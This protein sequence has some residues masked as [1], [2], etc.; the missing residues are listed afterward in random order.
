[1]KLSIILLAAGLS[2]RMGQDKLL[3]S[4]SNISL[5]QSAFNL[6]DE[7]DAF[8]KIVVTTKSRLEQISLPQ[9]VL[10]IINEDPKRGQSSSLCLGV[11]N[12]TGTHYLFMAADQP[13][14]TAYDIKQITETAKNNPD[15]I[16][17]PRIGG[18]PSMPSLFP[19]DFRKKL[20][21]LT[22]DT[23]GRVIREAYPKLCLE[24]KPE[25]PENFIDIDRAEDFNGIS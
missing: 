12:T 19:A 21:A 3:M 7:I 6:L 15:K 23:G 22:G 24:I 8:E 18:K 4:K 17:Y 10:A 14:L 9:N 25:N 2:L 16:I 11:S 13:K 20:L 5:L 1:M